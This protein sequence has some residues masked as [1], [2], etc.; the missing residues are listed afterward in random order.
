M[1]AKMKR[2]KK[3]G[4]VIGII[5]FYIGFQKLFPI[6][7]P[8]KYFLHI[9]CAGCGMTRAWKSVIMGDFHKAFYHHPMYFS[10]PFMAGMIIFSDVFPKEVRMYFWY[11]MASLFAVIYGIRII[12]H[13]AAIF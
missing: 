9:P 6:G 2:L 1:K 8:F 4:L 3:L 5:I 11:I 12:L 7:C 10:V 13:S